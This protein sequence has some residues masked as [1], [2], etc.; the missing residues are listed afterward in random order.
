MRA[1]AR[2]NSFHLD[3][4]ARSRFLP[5]GRKP[6]ILELAVSILRYFPFRH[7]PPFPL[8]TVKRWVQ[9]SMLDLKDVFRCALNVLGDFVPMSWPKQQGAQDEHVQSPLQEFDPAG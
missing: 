6:V 7:D 2:V 9:R 8:E 1:I 3:S 5:A 4:S